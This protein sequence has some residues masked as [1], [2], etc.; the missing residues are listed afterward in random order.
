MGEGRVKQDYQELV[1]LAKIVAYDAARIASTSR[2]KLGK[3]KSVVLSGKET[4]IIA[5][6]VLDKIILERLDNTGISILSE[7]SGY[8]D[9]SNTDGLLWIVD[10]LDGSL[11]FSRK[12]GP[13]AVSIALWENMRPCFGVIY[14]IDEEKLAWGGKRFGAWLDQKPIIISDR[15]EKNLAT[16]CTGIPAR[17]NSKD[18][19]LVNK[20]NSMIFGFSKVRMTGSAACSLLLVA[21]GSA[22]AYWEEDIMLWDIAAGFAIVEGSGGRLCYKRHSDSYQCSAMA[23][24]PSLIVK[25]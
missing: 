20:F 16:L 10:P 2:E 6:R 5:D 24:N 11:N 7:E 25:I 12:S 13:C 19:K 8:L 1:D 22:D 4:K 21:S 3:I 17:F 9:R 14:L 23:P 18:S 15:S